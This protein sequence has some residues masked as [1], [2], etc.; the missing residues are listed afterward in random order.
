MQSLIVLVT[1]LSIN[2]LSK[3]AIMWI[4]LVQLVSRSNIVYQVIRLMAVGATVAD[5]QAIKLLN[6][7][8][9]PE[10]CRR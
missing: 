1:A 3:W 2:M 6:P 10:I 4:I 8:P 5:V 9:L 7:Q